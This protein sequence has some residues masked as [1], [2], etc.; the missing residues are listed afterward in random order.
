MDEKTVDTSSPEVLVSDA[1]NEAQSA[2]LALDAG[3]AR[4][5]AYHVE[6]LGQLIEDLEEALGL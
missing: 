6:R 4:L 5:V 1:K 3:S 2:L